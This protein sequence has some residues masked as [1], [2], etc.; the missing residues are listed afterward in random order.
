M[1]RTVVTDDRIEHKLLA[2]IIRRLREDRGVSQA[3]VAEHLNR[4]VSYVWKLEKPIQHI[5]IP[6]LFDIAE[7]LEADPVEIM[8]ELKEARQAPE[9]H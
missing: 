1:K 4:P 3:A 5:D 9:D 8:R 6:T 7:F 2:R